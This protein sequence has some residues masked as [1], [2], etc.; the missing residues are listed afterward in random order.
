MFTHLDDPAPPAPDPRLADAAITEGRRRL[1]RRRTAGGGI[2]AA[3]LTLLVVIGVAQLRADDDRN[4][5]AGTGDGNELTTLAAPAPGDV[6]AE[7]LA[8]GTPV[9]LV[10]HDDGSYTVLD[11]ASAHRPYGV[12]HLVGWCA[13]ARVFVDPQTGSH[14]DDRGLVIAGPAPH[15][16][17]AVTGNPTDGRIVITARQFEQQP[18]RTQPING[19]N[20]DVCL[21]PSGN[22]SG[23]SPGAL[24][25]HDLGGREAGALEDALDDAQAGD[26]LLVRDGTIVIRGDGAVACFEPGRFLKSLPPQCEGTTVRGIRPVAGQSWA[27]LDGT[28]LARYDGSSLADVRFVQGWT[29][30]TDDDRGWSG[31]NIDPDAARWCAPHVGDYGG[32]NAVLVAAIPR[33]DVYEAECWIDGD[34]AKAPPGGRSFD[35]AV[36]GVRPE[37]SAKIIRATYR[38]ATEAATRPVVE[39]SGVLQMVGGPPGAEPAPAPGTVTAR[40]EDG[41]LV[42]V[43][44]DEQGRFVLRL[45]PGTYQ[46]TGRSPQYQN[47]GRDCAADD[48]VV[49]EQADLGDIQVACHRR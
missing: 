2:G 18:R 17:D 31:D 47:G 16:L 43:E 46:L 39:V 28:F 19:E 33:D 38:D 5:I 14:Y 27:I 21:P 35:R 4:V 36:I 13:A 41:Q 3:A 44:T 24:V 12:A 34:V 32:I 7:Q 45:A 37:G 29:Q 8:D 20:G 30:R 22:P 42:W 10:G 15:G 40:G 1:R 48:P 49:V 25:L 6:V 11:A 26:L 9:W 23:S